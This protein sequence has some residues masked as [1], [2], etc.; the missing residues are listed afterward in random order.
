MD[1]LRSVSA[2]GTRDQFWRLAGHLAYV[3]FSEYAS[4]ILLIGDK[5]EFGPASELGACTSPDEAP[6]FGKDLPAQVWSYDTKFGKWLKALNSY[7]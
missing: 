5:H 1:E 3:S 2:K 4:K 6:Q 7:G